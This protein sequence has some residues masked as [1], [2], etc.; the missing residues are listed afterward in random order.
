MVAAVKGLQGGACISRRTLFMLTNAQ[1]ATMPKRVVFFLL[2]DISAQLIHCLHIQ[3]RRGRSCCRALRV[4][5]DPLCFY[6]LLIVSF[7]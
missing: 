2:G 3:A 7:V 1:Q 6:N 5:A 4:D